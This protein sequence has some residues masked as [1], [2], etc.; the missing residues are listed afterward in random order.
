MKKF[1]KKMWVMD[2]F[3]K[4]GNLKRKKQIPCFS[5]QEKIEI[6]KLISLPAMFLYSV[7]YYL[8]KNYI[9]ILK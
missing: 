1:F 7:A 2:S 6:K 4:G 3:R 8:N 9:K 5:L